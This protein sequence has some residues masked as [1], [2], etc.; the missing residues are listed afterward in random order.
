VPGSPH[1]IAPH[2]NNRQDAL[3]VDEDRMVSEGPKA[4]EKSHAIAKILYGLLFVVTLPLFLVLFSVRVRIQLGIAPFPIPGGILTGG[5]VILLLWGMWDLWRLGNGL[6]MNAFPPGKLVVGGIYAIVPHPIY[7]GFVLACLGVSLVVGSA[8]G[9][10][11]TTPLVAAAAGCLG[12]CWAGRNWVGR[13][14]PSFAWTI[15]GRGSSG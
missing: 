15:C 14:V 2:A 9:A 3:F 13:W 12:P 7:C 11:L 1:H 5:G 8:T 6:P 4:D 10:F